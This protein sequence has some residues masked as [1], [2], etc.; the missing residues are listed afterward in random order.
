MLFNFIKNI[1]SPIIFLMA[2]VNLLILCQIFVFNFIL[3]IFNNFQQFTSINL[4]LTQKDL[5]G[6][7]KIII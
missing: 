7:S 4:L 1:L 5:D 3:L 6:A 2:Y